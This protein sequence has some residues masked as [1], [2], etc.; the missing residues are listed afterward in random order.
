M[1]FSHKRFVAFGGFGNLAGNFDTCDRK[2]AKPI[3]RH[4]ES[5]FSGLFYSNS[6]NSAPV[7]YSF[8]PD[9]QLF[10]ISTTSPRMKVDD[11]G[12]NGDIITG[13]EGN[14]ILAGGSGND[15]L[16]GGSGNDLVFGGKEQ[17]LGLA[18]RFKRCGMAGVRYLLMQW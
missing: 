14:D 1:W 4:A 2:K 11:G 7:G 9:S 10:M 5:H 6:A 17:Q 18:R 15:T 3:P 16:A 12:D 8:S 13:N